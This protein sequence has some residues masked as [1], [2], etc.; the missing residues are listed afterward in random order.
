MPV[1][2]SNLGGFKI[3]GKRGSSTYLSRARWV[4]GKD[5]AEAKCD[6]E[7]LE[8]CMSKEFSQLTKI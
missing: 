4:R 6:S 3:C 1:V 8:P 7:A 5:G 2:M